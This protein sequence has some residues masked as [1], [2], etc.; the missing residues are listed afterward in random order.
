M[1]RIPAAAIESAFSSDPGARFLARQV[2]TQAR[3]PSGLPS[4]SLVDDLLDSPPL[5]VKPDTPIAAVAERM[6]VRGLDYAAVGI[7][8]ARYGL[9]TDSILRRR[10]LVDRL[11]LDTPAARVMHSP[12][13][14]AR[15]GDSAAEALIRLLDQDTEFLLVTDRAGELHGA[16]S[17]R[18]L[19]VSPT[20]AGVALHEQI[21]RCDTIDDL[22]E[23]TRTVPATLVNILDGGL[24]S[25]RVI[26]LYGAMLDTIIRRAIQLVFHQ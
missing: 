3:H 22:V 25:T 6:T 26:A 5:V 20:T 7:A 15:L 4:Y 9:I 16:I 12:A 14:T 10:I 24:S 18:D 1:A 21:R 19:V 17:P 23:R 11:P 13:N 8:P 2:L